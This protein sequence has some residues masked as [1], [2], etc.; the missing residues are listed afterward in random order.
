MCV[1]RASVDGRIVRIFACEACVD[2]GFIK[3]PL[4][5]VDEHCG[6]EFSVL[7]VPDIEIERDGFAADDRSGRR[8]PCSAAAS[9]GHIIIRR[10]VVGFDRAITILTGVLACGA[11]AVVA[12]GHE[13][14]TIIS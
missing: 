4:E 10:R 12:A 8:Q 7:R 2:L 14:R 11:E 5:V 6:V 3:H 9:A 1:Y 13:C